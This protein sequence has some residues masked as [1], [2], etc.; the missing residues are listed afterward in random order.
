MS[1]KSRSRTALLDG[2]SAFQKSVDNPLVRDQSPEADF[3]RRGLAVASYNLLETFIFDRCG[4]LSA[5]INAGQTQFLDLPETFQ[6]RAINNS[7]AVA[8]QKMKYVKDIKDLRLQSED[9]G[10]SLSSVG[11]A[12]ELSQYALVWPGSNMSEDDF[13][14]ALKV[15]GVTPPYELL[16][17]MLSRLAFS[18]S[19]LNGQPID[20]KAKLRDFADERHQCAHRA[21]YGIT[22]LVLRT[23]PDTIRSYALGFDLLATASAH[24]IHL[25]LIKHI[26]PG[27][28]FDPKEIRLR[29]V[30]G[31][32]KGY[33]EYKEYA[34]RS[35][36]RTA[37]R[38]DAMAVAKG[39][40]ARLEAI[41]EMQPEG[42]VSWTMPC[43]DGTA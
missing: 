39:H 1:L 28:K 29:F 12:I 8:T 26:T 20:L 36:R 16:H 30:K 10:L 7:I 15:L 22:N 6:K 24:L 19:D 4:E 14:A 31:E 2:L 5:H 40:A 32:N 35:S 27:S 11:R 37:N 3:V 33:G 41:V 25:G 21:S 18:V 43:V 42:V 23:F 17:S 34:R 13:G 38:D 9:L